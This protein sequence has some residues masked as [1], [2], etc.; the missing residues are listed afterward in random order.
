MSYI[1]GGIGE[2]DEVLHRKHCDRV[3]KGVAWTGGAGMDVLANH[4]EFSA[5]D[6]GARKLGESGRK[7]Y[8]ICVNGRDAVS[9]RKVRTAA[10]K[11]NQMPYQ[12]ADPLT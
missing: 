5:G 12:A 11:P 9:N 8:V 4:V 3:V 1:R 7:G 10:V 2:D 6:E